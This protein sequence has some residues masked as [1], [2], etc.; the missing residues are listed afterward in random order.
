VTADV[1]PPKQ[2]TVDVALP[3]TQDALLLHNLLQAKAKEHV[4]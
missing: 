2:T 1:V 4:E 3:S